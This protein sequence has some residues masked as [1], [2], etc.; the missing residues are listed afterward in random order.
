MYEDRRSEG[1]CW[2]IATDVFSVSLLSVSFPE[3]KQSF[4]SFACFTFQ[5]TKKRQRNQHFVTPQ[6]AL[7]TPSSNVWDI[8]SQMLR[9]RLGFV[10]FQKTNKTKKKTLI[11]TTFP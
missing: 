8:S 7:D 9:I 4:A 10:P 3:K 2:V 11:A 6:R 5:K 1:P